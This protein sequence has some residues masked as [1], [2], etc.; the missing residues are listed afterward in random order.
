MISH[1]DLQTRRCS[2]RYEGACLKSIKEESEAR[3]LAKLF[4]FLAY[5]APFR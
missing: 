2:G 1:H 3:I 5:Q 4:W